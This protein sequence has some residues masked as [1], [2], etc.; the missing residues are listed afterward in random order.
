[1]ITLQTSTCTAV[2][3]V[4]ATLLSRPAHGFVSTQNRPVRQAWGLSSSGPRTADYDAPPQRIEGTERDV[5]SA[6]LKWIGPYPCLGLTFPALSTAAQRERKV[7][8][9]SLDFVIDSAANI[10]TINGQVAKELNLNETGQALPGVG[11]AGPITGNLPTFILGNAKLEGQADEGLFMTGLTAS[12]LPVASPASAGLLSLAFLQTFTGGVDFCW[13]SKMED[14]E[15]LTPAITFHGT[16]ESIDTTGR[17][18][19]TIDRIPI[20]QLPSLTVRINGVEM[21]A[22]LDTGSPITVLNTQAAKVANVETFE[23]PVS[24]KNKGM[25]PF[26]AISEQFQ[27]TKAVSTGNILT[28][29]GASG[30]LVNLL[31]SQEKVAVAVKG[32]DGNDISFGDGNVYVGDLPGLAALQGLGVDSPPAVVLGMDVL[33]TKPKMLLRAQ[34]NEVWF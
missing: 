9:I 28:I 18:R 5:V 22:L 2:A 25:N 13:G 20:T 27:Q 34:Q 15:I 8:G 29:M 24:R 32:T 21:P 12:S 16:V 10:N 17:Q 26:A 14:D 4:A 1:M 7:T 23:N 30:E 3:L 11:T 33:R 19:A 31:K 6:P